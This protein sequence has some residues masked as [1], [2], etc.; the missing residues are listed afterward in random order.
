MAS[1]KCWRRPSS[2][3]VGG[4][5]LVYAYPAAVIVVFVLVAEILEHQ[6]VG[7]GRRAI[8]QLTELLPRSATVRRSSGEQETAIADLQAGDVVIVKPGARLPV[9]GEV[10]AGHSFVDQATITGESLPVE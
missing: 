10:I 2:S 1:G 5:R 6:T 9:D 8:R 3:A 7:R 4:A